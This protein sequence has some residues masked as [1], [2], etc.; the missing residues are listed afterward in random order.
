MGTVGFEPATSCSIVRSCLGLC[1]AP[2]LATSRV[3]VE[4][5]H[6]RAIGLRIAATDLCTMMNKLSSGVSRPRN[7]IRLFSGARLR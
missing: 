3:D 1:H 7:E 5:V 6:V 4:V 2:T